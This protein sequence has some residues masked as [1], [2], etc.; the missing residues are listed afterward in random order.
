MMTIVTIKKEMKGSWNKIGKRIRWVK[1]VGSGQM[2]TGRGS[3]LKMG[4]GRLVE[5]LWKRNKTGEL[6]VQ[7]KEVRVI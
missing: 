7:R 1:C 6:E 2:E 5:V 3:G 4:D